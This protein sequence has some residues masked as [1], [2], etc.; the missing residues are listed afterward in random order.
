MTFLNDITQNTSDYRVEWEKED[1]RVI[2]LFEWIRII[3][4]FSLKKIP[5]K[6]S[7]YLYV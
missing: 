4:G 6:V 3:W 1:F 5:Q 2:H 7:K